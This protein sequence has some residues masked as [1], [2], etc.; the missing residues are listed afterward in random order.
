M[1]SLPPVSRQGVFE[2][3]MNERGS[4]PGRDHLSVLD[5]TRETLDADPEK[6]DWG[7]FQSLLNRVWSIYSTYSEQSALN[8]ND[9]LIMRSFKL[10]AKN[11][12]FKSRKLKHGLL[13]DPI[14]SK[15][16]I[17]LAKLGKIKEPQFECELTEWLDV[18]GKFREVLASAI[19]KFKQSVSNDKTEVLFS[20]NDVSRNIIL[21]LK[22]FGSTDGVEGLTVE[23]Y[24]ASRL[25]NDSSYPLLRIREESAARFLENPDPVN[26]DPI[27]RERVSIHRR[28]FQEALEHGRKVNRLL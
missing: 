15:A 27:V 22:Y 9:M 3:F 17:A 1:A 16:L 14:S 26:H 28:A 24:V 4:I 6:L 13:P 2:R 20:N 8:H 23:V 12:Y 7:T 25:L 21:F 10:D 18:S 19:S 11:I 5:W